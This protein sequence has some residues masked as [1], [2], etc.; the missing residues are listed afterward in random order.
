MTLK[1]TAV[2][3]DPVA[4]EAA[5][6]VLLSGGSALGAV[7]AGFLAAAG[8]HSGVL[9]SPITILS[10]GAGLGARAFDGRCRQPGLGTKRPRG[11]KE[12]EDIP[13]AAR[14][15]VPAALTAT[16]VAIAYDEQ[17]K[18]SRLVKAGIRRAR[19]SG[20]DGRAEALERVRAV[21][22]GALTESMFMRPLLHAGGESNGGVLTS[23]DLRSIDGIDHAAEI[24]EEGGA[25][26]VVA[27]WAFADGLDPVSEEQGTGHAICSVD[28]RGACAVLAYRRVMNGVP[29]EELEMDAPAVA[30]PV[31]RGVTRVAPGL[32]LVAP[33][34]IAI[35]VDESGTPLEA[36][37]A[38]AA[39]RPTAEALR[40]AKLRVRWDATARRAEVVR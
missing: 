33:A 26:W 16:A 12:G 37:A 6:D 28:V 18:L 29:V 35:R 30:V 31:L 1:S 34:P 24:R 19:D 13:L 2:A 11:F 8:A 15:A 36:L 5:E 23:T 9:L 4:A 21:G 14:L 25:R 20:A 7:V 17:A 40:G 27:P 3:D 32:S 10:A 22:A 39:P 38:P